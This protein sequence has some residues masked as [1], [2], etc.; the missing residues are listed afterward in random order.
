MGTEPRITT[1]NQFY[2]NPNKDTMARIRGLG[3]LY[4]NLNI[5]SVTTDELQINILSNL[6]AKHWS[7]ALSLFPQHPV[8]KK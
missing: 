7:T 8:K 6:R 5:E 3:K 1:G 4:Y 2:L